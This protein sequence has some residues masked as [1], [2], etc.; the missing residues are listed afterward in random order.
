MISLSRNW[1]LVVLR[2]VLAILFGI[3]AFV[4]PAVTWLTLIVMFG[5][6]AIVDGLIA[7]GTGL[8]RTKDS[9]RWWVFLLEGLLNIGAGAV[10]LIWP[11]LTALVLIYIIASWA[12]ITGVLEIAAAVRLR[13]EISNEWLLGLGG[14]VSMVLGILLFLQPGA[15]GLALIWIIAG[16]ALIFGVLLVILGFR[17]KN[18]KAPARREPIP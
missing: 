16:Y 11:G 1:W 3:L 5:V 12:V 18:W 2:G 15:G 9:P 8:S 4:W 6:Y 7:I 10:A 17:L 13:D 14:F